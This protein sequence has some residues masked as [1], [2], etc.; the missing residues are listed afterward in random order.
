MISKRLNKSRSMVA[1]SVFFSL[2]GAAAVQAQ[3]TP[4]GYWPLDDMSG[5]TAADASGNGRNGTLQAG[6][7]TSDAKVG[8][9]AL[10]LDG[11]GGVDVADS[12]IDT[13]KSFT[14]S[15]WVKLRSTEGFQTFVSLDGERVSGFFLQLRS[16][17]NFGMTRIEADNPDARGVV[18]GSL[19]QAEPNV[20]YHLIGV[21]DA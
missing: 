18:A 19:E 11:H 4:A 6:G 16:S 8:K 5:A 13:S 1:A 12:V 7:W 9:S 17:G 10:S 20:W 14:V 21:H 2:C 3:D 15:A